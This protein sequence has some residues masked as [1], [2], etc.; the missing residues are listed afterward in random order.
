MP[1]ASGDGEIAA[2]FGEAQVTQARI[3]EGAKAMLGV[4]VEASGGIFP[5]GISGGVTSPS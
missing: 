3:T 2:F 4:G 1:E 5:G